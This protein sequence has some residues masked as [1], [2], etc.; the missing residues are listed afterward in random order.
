MH[1]RANLLDAT[2]EILSNPG[3]G[4]TVRFIGPSDGAL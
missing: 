1:E 2:L 4:T 3:E